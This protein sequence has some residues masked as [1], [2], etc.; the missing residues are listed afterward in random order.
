MPSLVKITMFFSV[1]ST[2]SDSATPLPEQLLVVGHE[3][4]HVERLIVPLLP[5]ALGVGVDGRGLHKALACQ[6]KE[7]GY[8]RDGEAVHPG[9]QYGVLSGHELV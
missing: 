2:S 3:R 7:E 9:H 1:S 8:R 5:V 6:L 4:L